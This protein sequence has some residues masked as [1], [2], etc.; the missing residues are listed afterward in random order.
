MSAIESRMIVNDLPL[1]RQR[2][3]GVRRLIIAICLP[4]NGF[5]PAADHRKTRLP[6]KGIRLF[7]QFRNVG[8][9]EPHP[10]LDVGH[11]QEVEVA[12]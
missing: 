1:G 2:R 5:F 3:F 10:L 4:R 8:E 11:F 9:E 12:Y 6:A 7:R